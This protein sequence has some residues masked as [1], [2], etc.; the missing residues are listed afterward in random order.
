MTLNFSEVLTSFTT[1]RY[2][3]NN[4]L[5]YILIMILPIFIAF[6]LNNWVVNLVL[7]FIL[8]IFSYG[9]YALASHYEG[10]KSDYVL[11]DISSNIGKIFE[12]GFKFITG[13]S[14][15][16]I[17]VFLPF[18]LLLSVALAQIILAYNG[19]TVSPE[20]IIF[21]SVA[22]FISVIAGIILSFK[23]V[24]PATLLFF[25]TMLLSDMFSFS[26]ISSFGAK[27][28]KDFW[29]Y[30]LLSIIV[31]IIINV[32]VSCLSGFIP[33]NIDKSS[34]K[35]ID[36]NIVIQTYSLLYLFTSCITL[37][38]TTLLMSNLNGQVIRNTIERK[39]TE[40]PRQ[41]NV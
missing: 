32:V 37:M 7:L 11:I 24:I 40:K 12:I 1:N 30:I 13:L 28:S 31:S 17:I 4:M 21:I 36:I 14:T 8:T 9:Y 25:K 34:L 10:V 3:K 38:L 23:Y 18:I 35:T 29:M 22:S 6:F 2:N 41:V 19:D 16:Y 15:L 5:I 27:I 39:R 20:V 26:K 33:V